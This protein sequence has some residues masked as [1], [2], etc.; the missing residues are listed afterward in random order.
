MTAQHQSSARHTAPSS[1]EPSPASF[2]RKRPL[3]QSYG[4]IISDLQ[5]S[6]NDLDLIRLQHGLQISLEPTQRER[7]RL[8]S[9][10]SGE[11]KFLMDFVVR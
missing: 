10:Y 1:G 6:R 3:K 4:A 8:Q 11:E 2:A 9:A 7:M 5:R